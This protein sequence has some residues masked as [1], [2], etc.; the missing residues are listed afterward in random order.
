MSLPRYQDLPSCPDMPSHKCSWG[1]FDKQGHKDTVGTLNLLTPEVARKA[2]DLVVVG[3]SVSLDLPLD[4]LKTPAFRRK[5]FERK[6]HTNPHNEK[7]S[8]DDEIYINTQSSSQWDGHCHFGVYECNK[9]YNGTT[10][11]EIEAGTNPG[12]S[13]WLKRGGVVGRGVLLDYEEYARRHGILYSP[14]ERH[15]ITIDDLEKMIQEQGVTI[16][17][18]DILIIRSGLTAVRNS[19]NNPDIFEQ[20]MGKGKFVGVKGGSE[21][22]QWL[23]DHKVAAVAGDTV[24]FEAWPP[25][26]WTES[27]HVHLLA[28]LGIPLGELWNLEP[29]AQKCKALNRYT[30]FLTS[31]PLN[32][33]HGIAS[34]PNALAIF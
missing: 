6:V 8:C 33:T 13:E 20:Q 22:A 19:C 21:T 25:T 26:K 28:M 30:F 16:E 23:W 18:G 9:F 3:E 1:L 10:L 5:K 2:K 24:A 31:A 11:S 12:I 27:L 7:L 32:V 4:F 14:V 29:L 34:P 17:Q 15:E